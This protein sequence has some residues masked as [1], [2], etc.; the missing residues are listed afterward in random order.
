MAAPSCPLSTCILP[1][2][3]NCA[4][5]WMGKL[6]YMK[7]KPTTWS[8]MCWGQGLVVKQFMHPPTPTL[9][10]TSIFQQLKSPE[11]RSLPV[12]PNTTIILSMQ[13][14]M[15]LST[16]FKPEGLLWWSYR[17]FKP[18]WNDAVSRDTGVVRRSPCSLGSHMTGV[19]GMSDPTRH[20]VFLGCAT[21]GWTPG[22]VLVPKK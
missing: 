16:R 1:W 14:K 3:L 9:V 6:F 5:T 20:L 10:C 8:L 4:L 22:W 15:L 12:A 13:M 21:S 11:F 18:A 7:T 2:H 17:Q 19:R